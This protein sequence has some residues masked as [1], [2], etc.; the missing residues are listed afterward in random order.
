MAIQ[1]TVLLI[2]AGASPMELLASRI[3]R[4]GYRAVRAK[5]TEEAHHLL[6]DP[7]F[8]IGA[9]VVPPDLPALDLR[10]ALGA[11][12]T[13]AVG[14]TLPLL[15]HGPR[16]FSERR[17]E[18]ANAGVQYALWEPIDAHS[19][20]FQLNRA[21]AGEV[22][23]RGMRRA[24]RAPASWPVEPRIGKRAKPARVYT[25]SSRGSFLATSAPA[26]RGT[27]VELTLPLPAG[28]VHATGRVVLT[29]VPGNLMKKN[30]P[31]GMAVMFE[32]A[33]GDAEALLQIYAEERLRELEV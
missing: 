23:L 21:L 33:T 32:N 4:L 8:Q 7:R 6:V 9:A 3:R 19:L 5:T 29:N 12:R 15:A 24:L 31:S 2:D 30:L 13:L 10:G 14:G 16:P 26:L 1:K 20:R 22:P 18:L 11:L 27:P 28:T 17:R 25:V